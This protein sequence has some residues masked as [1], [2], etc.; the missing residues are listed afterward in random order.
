MDEFPF[1][2]QG[3]APVLPE[4][5]RLSLNLVQIRPNKSP[6]PLWVLKAYRKQARDVNHTSHWECAV[7]PNNLRVQINVTRGSVQCSL[8]HHIPFSHKIN[9]ALWIGAHH[10]EMEDKRL[11]RSVSGWEGGFDAKFSASVTSRHANLKATSRPPLPPTSSSGM[12]WLSSGEA[13]HICLTWF[14]CVRCRNRVQRHAKMTAE[15]QRKH[16]AD[17]ASEDPALVFTSEKDTRLKRRR[18][19]L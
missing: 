13:H 5:E 10:H 6:S 8:M 3:V 9:W 2:G 18:V 4:P 16:A 12:G 1:S 14:R 11:S 15:D 19:S 17:Q 7:A